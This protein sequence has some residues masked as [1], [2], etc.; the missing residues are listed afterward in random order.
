LRRDTQLGIPTL[1][2]FEIYFYIRPVLCLL[3]TNIKLAPKGEKGRRI[4]IP[5][6][7]SSLPHSGGLASFLPSFLARLAAALKLLTSFSLHSA[8][9]L[10]TQLSFSLFSHWSRYPTF[11]NIARGLF[12]SEQ[13]ILA[14]I[15]IPVR[16]CDASIN[17]TW[18]EDQSALCI[19]GS[20][21]F[22]FCCLIV[23]LLRFLHDDF[24]EVWP[25]CCDSQHS[26]FFSA[27]S[28][29]PNCV[30]ERP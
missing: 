16:A 20:F 15:W 1:I 14:A 27:Y 2:S 4:N 6:L 29:D 9:I 13:P 11:A 5:P 19:K 23:F 21:R 26:M 17:V 3:K 24:L 25:R 18:I 8:C 7:R 10:Q 12:R 22:S 30:S 28:G